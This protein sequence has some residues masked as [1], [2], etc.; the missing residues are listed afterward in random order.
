MTETWEALETG[1]APETTRQSLSKA[2]HPR[3]QPVL[4][5]GCLKVEVCPGSAGALRVLRATE[6]PRPPALPNSCPAKNHPHLNMDGIPGTC[7][8]ILNSDCILE[9]PRKVFWFC[10][11]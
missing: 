11:F 9:S 7:A 6:E 8:V 3:Q 10:Y 2:G 1:E 5:P 4:R